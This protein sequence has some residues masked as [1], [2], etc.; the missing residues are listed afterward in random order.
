MKARGGI[1][2]KNYFLN[3]VSQQFLIPTLLLTMLSLGG[4]GVFLI[5]NNNASIHRTVDNK[6][7][8]MADLMAKI[9]SPSYQNFDFLAVE[10]LVKQMT[11][12]PEVEFAIFY[13]AQKKPVTNALKEKQASP[14]VRVY[15]RNVS[16]DDKKVLGSLRIG[17]SNKSLQ[18]NLRDSILLV[19]VGISIVLALMSFGLAY[20]VRKIIVRRV[21]ETVGMLKNIADGE[22]DLTQRLRVTSQDELGELAIYF[23]KFVHNIEKIIA[24]VKHSAGNVDT[25]TSRLESTAGILSKVATQGIEQ[26]TQAA[27]AANQMENAIAETSKNALMAAGSA[28]QSSEFAIHGNRVV[29]ETVTSMQNIAKRVESTACT[30]EAL[31]KSSEQISQIVSVIK[32]IANQTNLLA[33]NAAIEAARAGEHGRGFA[34]VADEVRNLAERTSSAT[35]EISEMIQQIQNDTK[36][37]VDAM[38]QG[39]GEVE[40][41][42]QQAGEAQ[43]ALTQ[44]VSASEQCLNWVQMIADA[45]GEQSKSISYI[46]STMNISSGLSDSS[47][48]ESAK[49]T[50]IAREMTDM[51]NSLNSSVS[52]FKTAAIAT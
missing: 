40:S 34:V 30:V 41:G 11:D 52:L 44:I 6:A 43:K 14:D 51:A 29:E 24:S 3:T 2:K 17:Y 33:L 19:V 49:I 9:S 47:K 10:Q 20:L 26:S 25:T 8:A 46:S 31:G 7:G 28:K 22:G 4:L 27:S 37:S 38:R 15:E 35:G 21:Q 50:T 13:D 12:D 42:V 5:M 23:N 39:R 45:T 18:D 36:L 1:M 32:E 48:N 16:G